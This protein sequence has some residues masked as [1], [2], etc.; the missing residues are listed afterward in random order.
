MI[1]KVTMDTGACYGVRE[2]AEI[3]FR[4]NK[5]MKGG[6]LAVL[7]EKMD[8]LEPPPLPPKNEIYKFLVCDRNKKEAGPY[9]GTE[10]E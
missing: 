6:E 8:T 10:L 2:C 4:K 1:V 7:E 5:M 3:A 9:N